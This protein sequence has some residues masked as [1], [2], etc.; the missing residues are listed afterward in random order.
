MSFGSNP[1]PEWPT[2]HLETAAQG[3]TPK[4]FETV[5]FIYPMSH[6]RPGLDSSNGALRY[7]NQVPIPADTMRAT[8]LGTLRLR[9]LQAK[10]K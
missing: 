4:S 9:G 7:E 2:R 1:C 8:R 6:L 3:S 10:R 5:R